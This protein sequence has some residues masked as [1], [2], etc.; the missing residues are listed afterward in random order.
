MACGWTWTLHWSIVKEA[1]QTVT[2]GN[3][4]EEIWRTKQSHRPT[5]TPL[6]AATS[7]RMRAHISCHSSL[8]RIIW[9]GT[10]FHWMWL[11]TAPR[12]SMWRTLLTISTMCI[13]FMA[14]C[15]P[16]LL[17][18]FFQMQHWMD[19]SILWMTSEN[20]FLAQV[21]SLGQ[22]NSLSTI[23]HKWLGRGIT[24]GTQLL[25]LWTSI[26]LVFLSLELMSAETNK[27][28]SLKIST[29]STSYVLDGINC[30]H[31]THSH[32]L[33]E[34]SMTEVF[35]LS[36]MIFHQT[37]AT[38]CGL[39]TLS[40]TDTNTSDSCMAACLRPRKMVELVSIL[41]CSIT[42]ILKELTKTLRQHSWL[43]TPLKYPQFLKNSET[44]QST[45][46]SSHKESG[47]IWIHMKLLMSPTLKVKWLLWPLRQLLKS[48]WNQEVL[49]HFNT[50][51]LMVLRFWQVT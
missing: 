24:W 17:M 10:L 18:N 23:L 43:A 25:K 41:F 15:S 13:H 29:K 44:K 48:I 42:Q 6:M 31:S 50:I 12:M 38:T 3:P 7:C 36:L 11:T 35:S 19:S 47:W 1:V 5:G 2:S 45:R 4:K 51:S 9:I 21:L 30:Q 32:E 39:N 27:M 46:L 26:C 22:D 8:R 34:M 28:E 49:F 33:T 16:K 14:I 20:S 40:K 37:R